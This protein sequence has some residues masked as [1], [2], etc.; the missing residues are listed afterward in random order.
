MLM[1][2][3]IPEEIMSQARTAA[4]MLAARLPAMVVTGAGISV[5]SNIPPFRGPGGLW[6]KYDPYYH[7]HIDTFKED[8]YRTW[9]M[10]R[11]IIEGSMNAE[12]NEA[13]MAI[14]RMEA[15]GWVRPVVT[16]NVDGLHGIA[17][18]RELLEV[19]GNARRIY[20]P[21]CG[22]KEVLDRRSWPGFR[23][24]CECGAIK[25]PDIVFF[26]ESLPEREVRKAFQKA[27]DGV[28]LIV[29][30]TSGSVQPVSLIPDIAKGQGGRIVE[31]NP[32]RGAMSMV[33]PDVLILSR[34]TTGLAALELALNEELLK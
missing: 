33:D 10:L 12:P 28:D 26:G 1:P 17:G 29:V 30:G 27:Y 7:G 4:R 14:S 21:A 9:D 32:D 5:E 6:E 18:T 13:H 34:A 8:P 16:Q 31:I 19:H 20:C 25:R 2:V 3:S 24:E 22:R 11:E 23:T 15:N